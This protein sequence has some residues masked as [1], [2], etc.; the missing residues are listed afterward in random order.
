LI[1]YR[2]ENIPPLFIHTLLFSTNNP[3]MILSDEKIAYH[4]FYLLK[5][6]WIY[7]RPVE[8]ISNDESQTAVA[9]C[10]SKALIATWVYLPQLDMS[11]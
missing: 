4:G 8:P 5:N 3:L 9:L 10:P 11:Q 2:A 1:V 6:D 7:H